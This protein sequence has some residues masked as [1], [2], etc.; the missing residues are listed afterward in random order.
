MLG[1]GL[2]SVR[3]VLLVMDYLLVLVGLVLVRLN[4]VKVWNCILP[5]S[6]SVSLIRSHLVMYPTSN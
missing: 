2:V 3:V 6:R 1:I 4:K 5:A